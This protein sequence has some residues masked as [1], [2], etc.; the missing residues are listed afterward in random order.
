MYNL[1]NEL[2]KLNDDS[3]IKDIQEYINKMLLARG[4][5]GQSKQEIMLLLTEEIGE[6][7][8]EVRKSTN[9]KID[10]NDPKEDEIS[11]EIADVFIYIL[12]MCDEYDIDLMQ[13]LINKEKKNI[14]RVWK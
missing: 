1:E 8:K 13:A 2:S 7:A 4:F 9:M 6:L 14:K 5:K 11:D 3:T 12:T 10:Q